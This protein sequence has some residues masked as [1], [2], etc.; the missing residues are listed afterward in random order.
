[1]PRLELERRRKRIVA[2]AYKV[3][4]EKGYHET[5]IS[6]IADRLKIGHGTFY[7]YFENKLDIFVHVIDFV[8][9]E[10]AGVIAAEQPTASRSLT[11]YREQLERIGARL[12]ELFG[13][14]PRLAQLFFYE[15]PGIDPAI[16]K[17]LHR[18]TALIGDYTAQYLANGQKR[19]FLRRDMNVQV[20]ALAINAMIFEG[21]K[22]VHRAKNRRKTAQAWIKAVPQLMLEGMGA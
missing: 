7:R 6:D 17:R 9:A 13:K 3:F 14:D 8:M 12:F 1:M 5:N 22:W 19:R 16:D 15:A 11:D 21:L 4:G 18:M 2:A 10:V 20:T